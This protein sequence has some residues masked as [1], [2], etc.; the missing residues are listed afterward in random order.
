MRNCGRYGR[1]AKS[2]DRWEE[3]E[4]TAKSPTSPLPQ[5][6]SSSSGTTGLEPSPF[7]G[8]RRSTT[9]R[10][11]RSRRACAR[12]GAA[13]TNRSRR[14]RTPAPS[15]AR[16]VRA[17]TRDLFGA[18]ATWTRSAVTKHLSGVVVIDAT[19]ES[20]AQANALRREFAARGL[21]VKRVM[22]AMF[23][24]RFAREC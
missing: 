10:Q 14:L 1:R 9:G 5:A 8:E 21:R 15:N 7:R 12:I 22:F 3:L 2:S 20:A 24:R 11:T 19:G 6:R 23:S 16:S 17:R 13:L 18:C 4:T